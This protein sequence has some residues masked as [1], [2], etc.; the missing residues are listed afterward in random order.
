[1]E[2]R[3]R[4]TPTLFEH[5]QT[6]CESSFGTSRFSVAEVRTVS[7]TLHLEDWIREGFVTQS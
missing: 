4:G 6:E 3:L 5:F 1:M 7:E 2:S